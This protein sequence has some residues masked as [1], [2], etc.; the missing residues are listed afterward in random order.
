MLNPK[1]SLMTHPNAEVAHVKWLNTLKLHLKNT[2]TQRRFTASMKN[3]AVQNMKNKLSK[4]Y[5]S[6]Q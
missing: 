3:T 4:L 2:S 5:S 1:L 6:H